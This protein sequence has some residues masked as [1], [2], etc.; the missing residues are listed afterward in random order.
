MADSCSVLE[1]GV[2][3]EV[4]ETEE[5]TEEAAEIKAGGRDRSRESR[6]RGLE[7]GARQEEIRGEPCRLKRLRTRLS[8]SGGAE[9]ASWSSR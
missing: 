9:C 8:S 7:Q 3:T 6:E 1:A 5:R 2:E 4:D